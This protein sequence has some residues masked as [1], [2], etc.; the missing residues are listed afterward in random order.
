MSA[1]T[2]S[3][4]RLLSESDSIIRKPSVAFIH[5]MGES[6]RAQENT[7][8][9]C[10]SVKKTDSQMNDMSLS[11][12]STVLFSEVMLRSQSQLKSAYLKSSTLQLI[13]S[14]HMQTFQHLKQHWRRF[15]II[16]LFLCIFTSQFSALNMLEGKKVPLV[17]QF[18]Y[19]QSK[20]LEGG[21]IT[22]I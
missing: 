3:Q 8:N 6:S 20:A 14:L 9:K 10:K 11:L 22:L 4:Q 21:G 13:S 17:L 7:T 15:T 1:Y 16:P 12:N 5:A 18:T 2:Q 19:T